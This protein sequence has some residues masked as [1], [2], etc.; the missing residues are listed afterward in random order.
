MTRSQE[1]L[2]GVAALVLVL[3]AGAILLVRPQREAASQ[4]RDDE[5]AA[6]R[7]S[8]A[9]HDQIRALEVLKANEPALR[10]QAGKALAEFP[11]TPALPG[12]VNALQD[13]ADKA[14]VELAS[15]SPSPPKLSSEHPQLAEIATQVTVNGGY[16]EIQDFLSR[17]EDL[18]K[19]ADTASGVPPRSLLVGSVALSAGGASSTGAAAPATATGS[20]S[21]SSPPDQLSA[22]I[23]L[24]AFQMTGS[25]AG[26]TAG[27]TATTT[28]QV[29]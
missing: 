12:L 8:Q 9:L 16:F 28:T 10:E 3:V 29:R 17:L 1:R 21:D 11:P 19:G 2:L 23:T 24:S 13:M 7:E 20:G 25:A 27:G 15:V 14:G 26:T 6:Q 18:V 4:A 5:R 22:S